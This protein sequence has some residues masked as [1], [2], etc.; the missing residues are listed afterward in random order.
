MTMAL[1]E[2]VRWGISTWRGAGGCLALLALPAY[3]LA[4]WR[5]RVRRMLA[6]QLRLESA[7]Q[8][9]RAGLTAVT[10]SGRVLSEPSRVQGPQ[11]VQQRRISCD[12]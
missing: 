11:T 6:I 9:T 10:M 7:W 12:I 3:R 2:M 4:A 5:W 1:H 8:N